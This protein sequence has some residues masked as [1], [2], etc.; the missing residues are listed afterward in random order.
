MVSRIRH[1]RQAALLDR[2]WSALRRDRRATPPERLNAEAAEVVARL[3]RGLRPPD[4]PAAFVARLER[5]LDDQIAQQSPTSTRW[6]GPALDPTVRRAASRSNV[7][8][9]SDRDERD[10]E[11]RTMMSTPTDTPLNQPVPIRSR[12]RTREA[13]LIAAAIAAFVIVGAVLALAL[14][15][16]DD[17]STVPGV[18][19]APTSI[20]AALTPS[21]TAI[22][23]TGATSTVATAASPTVA[24]TATTAGPTATVTIPSVPSP[25]ETIATIDLSVGTH[26]IDAFAAGSLWVTNEDDA[27][28]SRIDVATNTVVATIPV[29]STI[30]AGA[31]VRRPPVLATWGDAVWVLN[32]TDRALMRIDVATN[33]I[34]ASFSIGEGPNA[35]SDPSNLAVSEDAIW[36]TDTY[37]AQVARIDPRSQTVVALVPDIDL[38]TDIGAT[39]DAVWLASV[40]SEQVMRIDPATNQIVARIAPEGIRLNTVSIVDGEVWAHGASSV[41]RIDPATNE[42]ASVVSV[43]RP[44][45]VQMIAIDDGTLWV[46]GT[47]GSRWALYRV[48][49]ATGAIRRTLESS[50]PLGVFVADGSLWLTWIEEHTITRIA[51]AP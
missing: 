51:P 10:R 21:A 40:G 36:V 49:I 9:H 25:G 26:F 12:S 50:D 30:P 33:T 37:G 48:D 3:E 29:G 34:A 24:A 19:P 7:S 16:G 28:V 4:A 46:A 44:I 17:D 32:P 8:D 31:V 5:R 6:R 11:G 18:S 41:V 39:A 35:L 13:A 20:P 45:Q 1:G 38:T 47:V 42:V 22:P 15:G 43:P 14:R 27:T 2:Y 23:T